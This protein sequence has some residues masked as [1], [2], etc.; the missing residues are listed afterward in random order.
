MLWKNT[1]YTEPKILLL[2]VILGVSRV[3]V[4][5]FPFLFILYA[6]GTLVN[7]VFTVLWIL[8]N[9]YKCIFV[10]KVLYMLF[11]LSFLHYTYCFSLPA[12]AIIKL[13]SCFFCFMFIIMFHIRFTP[14]VLWVWFVIRYLRFLLLVVS[15]DLDPLYL[16]DW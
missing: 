13:L 3:V 1:I 5:G 11:I 14:F 8:S 16:N 12:W 15:C 9:L 10:Y 7:S 2:Y 6:V 4:T